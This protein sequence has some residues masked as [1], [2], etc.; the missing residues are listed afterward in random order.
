MIPSEPARAVATAKIAINDQPTIF[1]RNRIVWNRLQKSELAPQISEFVAHAFR[2]SVRSS[3]RFSRHHGRMNNL[4][5]AIN[6]VDI[7]FI[8]LQ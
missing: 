7:Q 6:H 3:S 1:F 2:N 5:R 8:R 4:S